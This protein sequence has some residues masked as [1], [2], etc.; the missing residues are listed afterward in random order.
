MEAE[1]LQMILQEI[2]KAGTGELAKWGMEKLRG[3][4]EHMSQQDPKQ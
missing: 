4:L 2:A 3:L 1:W